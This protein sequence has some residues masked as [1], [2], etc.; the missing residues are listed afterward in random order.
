MTR[1]A[2]GA[3]L[4]GRPYLVRV[5]DLLS[6]AVNTALLLGATDE[7]CSGRA[8]RE[9][10]LLGC[11]RW[12]RDYRFINALFFWQADHCRGA[13]EADNQRSRLRLEHAARASARVAEC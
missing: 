13:Y 6:Q 1:Q 3:A 5:G 11:P 9:G 7:S 2:D 4:D 8:Y 10:V 12:R